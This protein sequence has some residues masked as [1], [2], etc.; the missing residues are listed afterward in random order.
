MDEALTNERGASAA[1]SL[2]GDH[3]CDVLVVG[4]GYTGLWTAL[5]M[6]D[7]DPALDVMMI[8]RDICGGGASGM[9]GGKVHGYWYALEALSAIFGTDGALRIARAGSRAQDGIRAF[10][11]APGRDVWWREGGNLRVS[12][13]PAH[14][15][16]IETA[17]A[18]ARRFGVPD[19]AVALSAAEVAAI[20]RSPAFRGGVFYPECATV[21]PARLV[22][23]LRA[24]AMRRGVRLHEATPMTGYQAGEPHRVTVEKGSIV[25]RELVLATNVGLAGERDIRRHVTL[26]SSYALMTEAAP[27]RLREIGWTGRQALSDMR[28]FLSYFSRTPD[29]RVLMGS[30]SGPFGYGGRADSPALRRDPATQGRVRRALETLLPDLR[31]VAIAKSWGGPIDISADRYPQIGVLPGKRVHYA[32]GFSGHGVNPTYIAGQ[33]LASM[34]LGMED[35]WSTLPLCNRKVV[36]LPPE[37]FRYVGGRLIREAILKCEEAE[38]AGAEPPAAA[39]FVAGLPK[40]LG[41]RIGV[42]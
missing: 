35:D 13:G 20:C 11:T 36:S 19:S 37:P 4:G 32:C 5:S 12:T 18:T 26:G 38:E 7:R 8:E 23:A 9:N 6:L 24:E 10:A 3:R 41:L 15:G 42:R 17:V 25:A 40:R 2:A 22:R 33:A 16:K 34:V 21:Q 30:G 14:D 39:R 29:D 31:D 1:P 27:E 28:M